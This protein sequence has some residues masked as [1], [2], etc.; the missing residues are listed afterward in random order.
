M[1]KIFSKILIIFTLTLVLF[2][3]VV[4]LTIKAK[5]TA[6][7]CSGYNA[8]TQPA[9]RTACLAGANGNANQDN[10]RA[11]S[12][13]CVAYGKDT[14]EYNACRIGAI[15][16]GDN[17]G[18][19]TSQSELFWTYAG[20]NAKALLI[21]GPLRIALM[22]IGGLIQIILIPVASII[23]TISGTIIDY[24]LKFTLNSQIMYDTEGSIVTVWTLIRDIFNITFIF[25]LLY[26][27]IKTIIGSANANTKKTIAQVI[28]AAILINF[29][30]F[31]TKV[32]ID[33]GNILGT[34][35]YNLIGINETNSASSILMGKS[36]LGLSGLFNIGDAGNGGF[37]SVSF[38]IVSTL[39]LLL[40]LITTITFFY[41]GILMIIRSIVLIFLMVLSPIGFMGNVLPKI[42]EYSKMWRENLY[43]MVF[44]APIFLLFFYLITL[45]GGNLSSDAE[46]ITSAGIDKQFLVYFK[47]LMIIGLLIVAVK[48]TKK[49]SGEMG[50]M[51]EKFG[52][53]AV[54]AALGVA[55]GGAALL[56]RQTIGRGATALANG[57]G[58]WA[59]AL[60]DSK[61][62]GGLGGFASRM[63][64]KTADYG[65]KAKF[66][67]R[68]TSTF[69]TTMKE[70]SG[71]TGLSFDTGKAGGQ[72]GKGSGFAGWKDKKEQD[73]IEEAKRR[74]KRSQEY[75]ADPA[76]KAYVD[77]LNSQ[78]NSTAEREA[79]HSTDYNTNLERREKR[80]E[81]NNRIDQLEQ[82]KGVL[83]ISEEEKREIERDLA[84][85][86]QEK[87]KFEAEILASEKR[88]AEAQ[89]TENDQDAKYALDRAN[90]K[91]RYARQVRKQVATFRTSG[92]SDKIATKIEGAEIKY[93][94][95][96]EKAAKNQKAFLDAIKKIAEKSD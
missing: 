5:T 46:K 44:V 93:D 84:K 45:I 56:G 27:A 96:K 9:E 39:Q 6:E 34:N 63:A 29:S 19:A 62:K 37:L 57:D 71:R 25:I 12:S 78:I 22:V 49:M 11:I 86:K 50:K 87:D 33:A 66:D 8:D 73:I 81:L 16:M 82:R 15:G 68:N 38:F 89:I 77:E 1:S 79:Q 41:I 18:S 42:E 90:A 52:G 65:S 51:A 61:E 48:T 70:V 59:T 24:S 91:K 76:N 67:A 32:V 75:L 26:T 47:Y 54:G 64:L 13:I 95:N 3:G 20:E 23:L 72:Y 17:Y 4:P 74:D 40:I 94:K 83:N 30:L 35:I 21:E 58:K 55:T 14:P 85:A 43:G 28:T 31:I 88:K 80:G 7:I 92:E 53:M 2:S 69:K 60:K 10:P 36:G